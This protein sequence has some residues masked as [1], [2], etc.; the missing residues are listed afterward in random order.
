[1]TQPVLAAELDDWFTHHFLTAAAEAL[2]QPD[3]EDPWQLHIFD[4]VLLP[5]RFDALRGFLE[6]ARFEPVYALASSP[7]EGPQAMRGQPCDAA[8]FDA[9][10]LDRRLFRFERLAERAEDAPFSLPWFDF[11]QFVTLARR[12]AFAR[13]FRPEGPLLDEVFLDVHRMGPGDFL[14]AHTD[15]HSR[16]RF[17]LILY[18]NADWNSAQ[19]GL[20]H[21]GRPNGHKRVIEPRPNRLVVFDVGADQWHEVPELPSSKAGPWRA[22]LGLWL[23]ETGPL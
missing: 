3:P 5:E 19:G 13:L 15:N 4:D 18:L 21:F 6:A 8:A 2:R 22:S 9:A 17:A 10:P 23:G 12:D 20:L 16:R 14:R 1:M 11:A 7:G